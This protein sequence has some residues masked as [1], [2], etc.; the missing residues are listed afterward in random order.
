[1]GMSYKK[2]QLNR[3]AFP[4]GGLGAGMLPLTGYGAFSQ[5]SLRHT[6]NLEG[7]VAQFSAICIKGKENQT[8]VLEGPIPSVSCYDSVLRW[9]GD[10]HGLPRFEQ[11]DFESS[12]PFATL[13]LSDD[14]FPLN[15]SVSA[16]SPFIIPFNCR[17]YFSFSLR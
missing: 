12:F 9:G 10:C 4:L 11:C 15:V 2:E 5:V 1:M 8:L 14:D 13:E 3:I 17:R 16:W 7:D 6:P